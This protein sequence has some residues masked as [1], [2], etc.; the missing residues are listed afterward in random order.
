[1]TKANSLA[2][3]TAND[4]WIVV[5]DDSGKH[6]FPLSESVH[7]VNLGVYYYEDDWKSRWHVLKGVFVKRLTHK[8]R[9]TACL[10][11]IHP[12]V[13][14]A[15]GQA[16]K[17]FLPRIKGEWATVREFHFTRDYRWKIAKSWFDYVSAWVGDMLDRVALRKYDKIVLLTNEDKEL[18]WR[19]KSRITVIPNPSGF[20]TGNC[21]SLEDK[22]VIA[23][24]RLSYPKNYASMIRAF[25]DVA[26]RFP[27]WR[28]DIYGDGDERD[29]LERLISDLS[30]ENIVNLLGNT[31]NVYGEMLHSSLLTLSSRFEGLPMVLIEAISCGL[32]VVSYACPC[33]PKDIITDGEDGFLVPVG[34]ERLLADR[35][36]KLIENENL[37]RKMGAAGQ[38]KSRQ[39]SIDRIIRMWMDLF[40]E[41]VRQKRQG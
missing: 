6:C 16:E 33:G 41:L 39:Y 5:A 30:L 38:E 12:D 24:G 11:R 4:V 27:D 19:K 31:Q 25:S 14:V 32:P 23:V 9:L 8:K 22:R 29:V 15:V 34:D 21:A 28:L 1:V 18:N 40:E 13:V 20:C 17:F 10:N 7:F 36:C 26:K 3:I 2:T 35:I 37:R